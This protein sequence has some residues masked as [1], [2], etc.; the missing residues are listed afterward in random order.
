MP[1][2]DTG[3]DDS[4][5]ERIARA[6]YNLTWTLLEKPDRTVEDDDAMLHAAH[7]SRHHWGQLDNIPALGRGE[8]LC[9]RVY[10]VLDRAEPCRHHAQRYLALCREHGIADWDLAFAYEALARA[11]AVAGDPLHAREYTELALA[12]CEEVDD[13][14][15]RQ[16]VLADLESIPNQDRF[17]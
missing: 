15:D 13:D 2:L 4:A 16:L 6:L 3:L 7:A 17:W 8:W 14:E 1:N 12:A 10:A 11:S 5:Q 9:S